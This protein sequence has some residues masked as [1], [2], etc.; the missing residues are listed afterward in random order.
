MNKD[1]VIRYFR[2]MPELITPRLVLRLMKKTDY[3]DMY[4]Y[5]KDPAVT[6]YLTWDPHPDANYTLR[7]ISYI[8]PK[9]R[10]GDFHDWAVIHK[11]HRK[12]IGT[13]G[14]TS[15]NFAHNSG[16]IGYVL[17]REYW[18]CGLAAE[19][20]RA[21]MRAGFM[22]LNLHRLEAKYM[23]GNERSRR[24]MEKCG[25]SFE[26]MRR[27]AMYIKDK[28]RNIGVCSILYEE[29]IRGV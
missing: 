25:M 8:L 3:H 29:Y 27:E 16:E 4:A 15:F 1:T 10:S 22:D 21:V 24:V 19:A 18:G 23:E 5:A 13:C 28:Y 14:F 26:G 6:E 20:V 2:D 11:E 17:N 12:M 9:Y 7:Y